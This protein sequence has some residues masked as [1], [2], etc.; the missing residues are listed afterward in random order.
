[1]GD[2]PILYSFRRC[3]YAMRA[4]MALLPSGTVCEIREVKLS[5]KP[6]ELAAAS[7]KATVPVLVLPDGAVIDQS[8]D[9]MRWALG[10]HDPEDWLER[11]DPALIAA[12]DGPFKHHLD[13]YKYPDRHQSDPAR[14]RA[15]GLALLEAL[16]G[17]FDGVPYLHGAERGLTDIAIFPFVR[18]FA[19]TDRGWFD[20]QPLLRLQAWLARNLASALFAAAMVRLEP[21]RAGQLPILFP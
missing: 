14:H 13:R 8:L 16:E 6:P 19:E 1:M 9:I 10:R 15:A 3:P 20:A 21:W 7:A 17:R 5:A 18:Q 4:R 11:D 2:R 12:N